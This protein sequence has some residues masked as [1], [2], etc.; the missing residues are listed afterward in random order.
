MRKQ[1]IYHDKNG[2]PS[3]MPPGPDGEILSSSMAEEIARRGKPAPPKPPGGKK[4]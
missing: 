3:E 2:N 4:K 1:A